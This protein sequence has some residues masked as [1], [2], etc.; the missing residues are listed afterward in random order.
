VVFG[1]LAWLVMPRARA[2]AEPARVALTWQTPD[3]AGCAT[4]REIETEVGR[5]TEREPI[6]RGQSYQIQALALL[7]EGRWVASVALLDEHERILGGREVTGEFATCRDLDVPVALVVST[8]LDGLRAPVVA[9]ASAPASAA[10]PKPGKVGLGAFVAGASG[11][12][13]TLAA[14]AGLEVQLPLAWPLVFEASAYLP[15]EQVDSAG[16]GARS[17]S[18][19]AGAS[20]CPRLFGQRHQLRLCGGLQAG[21][22]LAKGVGLTDNERATQPLVMVGLEPK[23][24][25]GL[26]KSWAA[27]L[28]LGVHVVALRPSFDWNIEGSGGRSLLVKPIALVARIGIIDFLR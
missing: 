9:P 6:T 18:F 4:Q 12:A 11:L 5:L 15:R 3:S 17:F 19:H 1:A 13:P 14:G 21:A 23:L 20:L 16:R 25:L 7:H 10:A 27:Q 28:S 22:A 2:Q 8:L 24:V 26:T